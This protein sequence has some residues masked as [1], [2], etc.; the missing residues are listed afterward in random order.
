MDKNA[1]K[2]FAVESRRKLIEDTKYQASLLGISANEI[3]EPISSA[4]GMETYQISASSTHTI[5]DE[6]IEQRK[7]LV[8]E[9]NK[10]GRAHV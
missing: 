8:Q 9:I 1:L 4:I 5:Y 2:T 3:K 10:I 6:E 7:H